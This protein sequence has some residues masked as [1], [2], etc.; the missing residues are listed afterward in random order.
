MTSLGE[1]VIDRQGRLVLGRYVFDSCLMASASGPLR[2]NCNRFLELTCPFSLQAYDSSYIVFRAFS[3]EVTF[4][5]A[6]F[7]FNELAVN[8]EDLTFGGITER[9]DRITYE[10]RVRCVIDNE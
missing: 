9:F 10:Y 8:G 6:D 2:F 4:L 5:V 7:A 3:G 1:A